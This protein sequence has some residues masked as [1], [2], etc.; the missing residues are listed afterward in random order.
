[1]AHTSKKGAVTESQA[2]DQ[3]ASRPSPARFSAAHPRALGLAAIS[4]I[5]VSAAAFLL[6]QHPGHT[7]Q[8][9]PYLLLAVCPLMHF[10]HHGQ[11]H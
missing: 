1:M 10:F 9:L 11:H 5:A 2:I 4:L 3:V 8:Y 6:T 7:L